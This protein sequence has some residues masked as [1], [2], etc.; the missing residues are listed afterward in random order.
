M[1]TSISSSFALASRT[2]IGALLLISLTSCASTTEPIPPCCYTG[3]AELAHVRDVKLA[4]SDGNKVSFPQ[5]FPGYQA[6]SGV[7]TTAFPFDEVEISQVTYGA[8]RPVLPQYDA[9]DNGNLEQPELTVLYIREAALGLGL[10]VDHVA[11]DKRVDAL[12]LPTGEIGGL[13]RYVDG[14]VERMSP[15]AQGI[16]KKLAMVGID[17]RSRGS[18]SNGLEKSNVFVP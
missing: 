7:F 14:N 11:T 15:E 18:E 12:V 16:F 5:A 3:D 13:V 6:Q 2:G 1:S 9:N 8:L 10:N 17:L 4:L